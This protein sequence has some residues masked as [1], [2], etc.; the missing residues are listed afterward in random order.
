MTSAVE[1]TLA[2][3]EFMSTRPEGV[4]LVEISDTLDL[5]RGACHRLLVELVQA[6][7]LRQRRGHGDY[8]LTTKLA[9]LGLSYLSNSGIVDLTQPLLDQMAQEAGDLVRLG[10][11]D[12]DRL[13]FVAKAQGARYG[14]RYD[15]D[16]GSDVRLSCS[17]AGHAWLATL[18]DERAM[19]LVTQQGLGDPDEF[20]PQ[21]PTTL[22]EVRAY[23]EQARALG[24]SMIQDVYANGMAAMAAP[25]RWQGGPTI[26]VISIAGPMMRLNEARMRA[27]GPRLMEVAAELSV[28]SRA[29]PLFDPEAPPSPA[30]A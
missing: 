19:T 24:F 30:T 29:S 1:R 6:G 4:P 17:A 11:V 21:A 26:G 27:L 15:P 9:A 18:S 12:G 16:M 13:T 8:L 7:F 3:L 23:L 2:V 22:R 10:I 28:V 14:L 20:G 5:P 25:I